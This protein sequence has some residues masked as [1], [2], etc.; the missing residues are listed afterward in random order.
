MKKLLFIVLFG[1]I[2]LTNKQEKKYLLDTNCIG[3]AEEFIGISN[4]KQTKVYL[5]WQGREEIVIFDGEFIDEIYNKF[6]E[7][8]D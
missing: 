2:L 1:L 3:Y 5:T 8:K 7:I 4:V 6:R